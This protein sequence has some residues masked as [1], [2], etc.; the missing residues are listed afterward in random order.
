MLQLI[1]RNVN[2][3]CSIMQPWTWSGRK[4]MASVGFPTR[5]T[6]ISGHFIATWEFQRDWSQLSKKYWKP[7][8]IYRFLIMS[9]RLL[10]TARFSPL[11]LR[12]TFTLWFMCAVSAGSSVGISQEFETF[13]LR[14]F[15]RVCVIF[16]LRDFTSV[17]ECLRKTAQR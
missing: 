12:G 6:R 5:L 17:L 13:S 16:H 9:K 4:W 8:A 10:I 7:N 14:L 11:T 2:Y 1:D 15:S 3:M